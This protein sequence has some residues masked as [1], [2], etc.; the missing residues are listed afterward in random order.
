MS[1]SKR[2]LRIEVILLLIILILLLV[3]LGV[4]CNCP[5]RKCPEVQK[6]DTAIQLGSWNILLPRPTT[7][8]TVAMAISQLEQQLTDSLQKYGFTSTDIQFKPYYCPCDSLLINVSV[9]LLGE[10]GGSK[11]PPNPPSGI[12]PVGG[13]S[14][15][16]VQYNTDLSI[17]EIQ[18]RRPIGGIL[19]TSLFGVIRTTSNWGAP[20]IAF[21]DTGLDSAYARLT[22]LN[23]LLI[24]PG[25]GSIVNFIP[26]ANKNNN[27]D[28][29][30]IMKHG[31]L[32]TAAFA[33]QS[34]K[35]IANVKIIVLKA[36]DSGGRG[37]SFST[38]CAI[39]Y[40]I[41]NKVNLINASWGYYGVPDS[42]L[43]HYIGLCNA[44]SIPFVAAAGNVKG[45]HAWDSVTY[46]VTP[47]PTGSLSGD[48]VFYPAAFSQVL[49][50]VV[51]VTGINSGV[52]TPCYYQDYSPAYVSVGVMQNSSVAASGTCCIFQPTRSNLTTA[53]SAGQVEGSSFEAPIVSSD[54]ANNIVPIAVVDSAIHII[55]GA[56]L[57]MSNMPNGYIRGNR[58]IYRNF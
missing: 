21:I 44:A 46:N 32:V 34:L 49:P 29:D 3:I 22:H 15:A 23:N 53:I 17:P 26:F 39:S 51:S 5:C 12:T 1:T 35:W 54:I 50:Y 16:S 47:N 27:L 2:W 36:L 37:T 8:D 56:G 6:K 10:S 43:L 9:T 55:S 42:I 52:M 19:D 38:S 28:D 40:A 25:P 48:S 41:Q 58:Y 18:N 24:Q 30:T 31:T 20:S 14:F 7:D 11:I 45:K 33:A 13:S 4:I 57:L